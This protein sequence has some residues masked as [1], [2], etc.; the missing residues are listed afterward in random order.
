MA[1]GA[2]RAISGLRSFF[3][4]VPALLLGAC[5]VFGI[6]SFT[7]EPRYTVRERLGTSVEIREYAPRLAAETTETGDEQVALRAGFERLARYISGANTTDSSIAMTAPVAQSP[8]VSARAGPMIATTA[9]VTQFPGAVPHQWTIRCFTPSRYTEATLPRPT[10][11]AIRIVTVPGETIAVYRYS[12]IA[13]PARQSLA[14]RELLSQ[15]GGSFWL[16]V[17]EPADWF[18]DPPWAIPPL[19]RNEA[20]VAVIR[21][22]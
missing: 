2:G 18:Y 21:M 7:E 10:D 15:L 9:P 3:A 8:S 14:Q 5:S 4:V 11:P 19:R 12:G 16:P 6:R 22:L 17:G 13:S 20:A 1:D